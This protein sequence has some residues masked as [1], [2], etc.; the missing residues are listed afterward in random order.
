MGLRLIEMRDM[1]GICLLIAG[2]RPSEQKVAT[3]T[4]CIG[5]DDASQFV[6][7]PV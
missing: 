7:A 6:G 5:E 3:R 4:S 2:F 1:V